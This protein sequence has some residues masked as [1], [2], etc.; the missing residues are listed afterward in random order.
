[1]SIMWSKF[2]PGGLNW[3]NVVGSSLDLCRGH[4]DQPVWTFFP[5]QKV[6]IR[7]PG[8]LKGAQIGPKMAI[9]WSKFSPGGINWLDL[10]GSSLDLCR[11]HR[12]QPVWTFCPTKKS[13]F[14]APVGLKGAQKGQKWLVCG[15]NSA[16]VV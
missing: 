9:P 5:T 16:P 1:M 11:G 6:Q 8:G 12:D 7:A 10:V 2:S 14:R 4:W 13:N 15:P 3:L